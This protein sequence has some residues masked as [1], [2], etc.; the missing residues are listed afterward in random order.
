MEVEANYPKSYIRIICIECLNSY[1]LQKDF[2]NSEYN[3]KI[4]DVLRSLNEP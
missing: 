2:S 3:F 1:V 4:S